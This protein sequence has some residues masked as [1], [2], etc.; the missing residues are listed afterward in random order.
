M[1]FG[2][3]LR[4]SLRTLFLED[5]AKAANAAADP[6]IEESAPVPEHDIAAAQTAAMQS[7]ETR[8]ANL[9]SKL[10]SS[11]FQTWQM[12]ST[13]ALPLPASGILAPEHSIPG[14]RAFP[15]STG[16]REDHFRQPYFAY[17]LDR[18]AQPMFYHRK[19]WEFAYVCQS[20]HERGML[21]ERRKGLGFGIGAESLPALFVAEGCEITATDMDAA[22]AMQAGWA[23]TSQHAAGKE[24][25]RRPA[26]CDDGKFEKGLSFRTVDMNHI[27]P[28]LEGFDFCWSACA[29]EHLGSI[30]LGLRF[31]ENSIDC[32]KPGGIA[33][34]TTEF[35]ISS[36]DQTLET[37]G[38]VLFRR[39]DFETLALRLAKN[40]HEM[41][42]LDFDPGFGVMDGYVDTAPFAL[43]PHLKL[44]LAGYSCTSFGVIVRKAG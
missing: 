32:L 25:L 10:N 35:N 2:E 11:I 14:T 23:G 1:T 12:F 36:N 15:F 22:E 30:E 6:A 20:L 43:Q 3:R 18:L 21:Q 4:L 34:H 24:A 31:I 7:S 29:L 9:E 44:A 28:D 17:W 26:I 8:L 40:G 13:L 42:P 5:T 41:A 19:L 38:T 39:R 16:C 37:G 33:V 27:P